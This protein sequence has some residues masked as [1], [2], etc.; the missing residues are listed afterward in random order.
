MQRPHVVAVTAAIMLSLFLASMEVTIVGTAMPTIVSQLGGLAVYS[1][2]FSAY[3]LASTTTVPIYGK[4]SDLFGR[5]PVY[6]FSIALF[7]IGSLLAG[8][9]TS[10]TQLILARAV[11]GLGAGGILPLAFTIIGDMFSLER[12]AKIQG[13]F[14]SVWGIS[15]IIGPLIGGFLVER[16]GWQWVFYINVFPGLIAAALFGFG[17]REVQTRSRQTVRVDFAGAALLSAGIVLLLLGLFDLGSP[18]GMLLVGASAIV[19][20]LLVIV[21]RRAADPILPV[22][23]FRDRLFLVSCVH[24]VLVGMAIFGSA[25]YVPLFAQTILRATATAAGATLT[26]QMLSWVV[27]S[28]ICSRLLLRMSYRTLAVFGM[29]MAVIGAALV[30]MAGIARSAPPLLIGMGLTGAGM[31]FSIPAF[32]I[33]VQ[34][35]VRRDKLGTATSTL[36]F[37]RNIGGTLGVSIM[38]VI[39]SA[40]LAATLAASGATSLGVSVDALLE[41][42]T[43]QGAAVLTDPALTSALAQALQGVFLFSLVTAIVGLLVTTWAPRGN[44]QQLEAQRVAEQLAT[45]M[46]ADA[47]VSRHTSSASAAPANVAPLR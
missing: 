37:S 44:V 46:S 1:W 13:L 38:G 29:A 19:F 15:S 47:S 39:L 27:T 21:E 12:R 32:T 6:F 41:R 18:Q 23:L 4:L 43:D 42:G 11:Q 16:V 7:L 22:A 35:A 31:G 30:L 8:S 14:S 2:V 28:I 25:S 33:A 10:M 3:L 40:G 26:P 17:W 9:A 5:R 20:A 45:E 24:G 36:T 34:S